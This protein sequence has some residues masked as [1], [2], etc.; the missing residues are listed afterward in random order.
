MHQARKIA[1]QAPGQTYSLV[2][3]FGGKIGGFLIAILQTLLDNNPKMDNLW[4]KSPINSDNPK[5]ILRQ[6]HSKI[7]VK[8]VFC[9]LC[10]IAYPTKQIVKY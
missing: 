6:F 4:D 10:G 3:T 9:Q 7:G 5:L 8:M 1:T 2:K